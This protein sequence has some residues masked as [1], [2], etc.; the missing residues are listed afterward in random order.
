MKNE[1]VAQEDKARLLKAAFLHYCRY[2]ACFNCG[3]FGSEDTCTD[4]LHIC[5]VAGAAG[6]TYAIQGRRF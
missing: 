5:R 4:T 6:R 1:T 2:D 3:L